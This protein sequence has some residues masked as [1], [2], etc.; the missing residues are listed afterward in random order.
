MK[1][2]ECKFGVIVQ[3]TVFNMV[4][5]VVGVTE[6]QIK[7]DYLTKTVYLPIPLIQFQNGVTIGVNPSN[8]RLY[9]E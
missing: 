7:P 5:M 2:S 1:L 8:L 4:G 6:C 9:E 3:D